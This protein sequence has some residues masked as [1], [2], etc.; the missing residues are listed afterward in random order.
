MS[1]GAEFS[2]GRAS[3]RALGYYSLVCRWL[4]E[5]R[6]FNQQ[7]EE[8]RR[9]QNLMATTSSVGSEAEGSSRVGGK[10]ISIN[11]QPQHRTAAAPMQELCRYLFWE[12]QPAGQGQAGWMVGWPVRISDS[13]LGAISDSGWCMWVGVERAT[14]EATTCSQAKSACN[15]SVYNKDILMNCGSLDGHGFGG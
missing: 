5:T 14:D 7:P 3:L 4:N 12:Q 13:I 2:G 11:T 8:R 6:H 10:Q 15:G 1:R 9:V